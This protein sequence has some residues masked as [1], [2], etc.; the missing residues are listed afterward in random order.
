MG[1]FPSEKSELLLGAKH[2]DTLSQPQSSNCRKIFLLQHKVSTAAEPAQKVVT[3]SKHK[4]T[5]L[6]IPAAIPTRDPCQNL[7]I[8]SRKASLASTKD[9]PTSQT[10]APLPIREDSQI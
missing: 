3:T 4:G 7:A 2:L 9:R 5:A 1:F 6:M 10:S 8:S